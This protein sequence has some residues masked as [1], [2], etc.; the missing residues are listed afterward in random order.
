MGRK[1]HVNS[2]CASCLFLSWELA[3]GQEQRR[4]LLKAGG[5]PSSAPLLGEEHSPL[6]VLTRHWGGL[7]AVVERCW[8]LVA[9]SINRDSDKASQGCPP[10]TPS[11]PRLSL[12]PHHS[13]PVSLASL[14]LLPPA[15]PVLCSHAC[16]RALA[17]CLWGSSPRSPSGLPF[18]SFRFCKVRPLLTMQSK[19][20]LSPYLIPPSWWFHLWNIWHITNLAVYWL[21]T[22]ACLPSTRMSVLRKHWCLFSVFS[23]V[24]PGLKQCLARSTRLNKC[25]LSEWKKME[26]G[27]DDQRSRFQVC[28]FKNHKSTYYSRCTS[29]T[30]VSQM[31]VSSGHGLPRKKLCSATGETLRK[32]RN[33][34]YGWKHTS[35]RNLVHAIS[36]SFL[37]NKECNNQDNSCLRP[38]PLCSP[39]T[40]KP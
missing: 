26:R 20:A 35:K 36:L 39:S 27:R 31:V 25:L 5:L 3:P 10:E 32:G 16:R 11:S 2:R 28:L 24:S 9:E 33:G 15:S 14:L 12:S 17:F 1:F 4:Q 19:T 22:T 21:S 6:P 37:R 8:E 34:I 40:K 38:L 13:T 23:A 29:R 7:M 30:R 18:P